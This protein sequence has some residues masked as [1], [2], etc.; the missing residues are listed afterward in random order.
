MSKQKEFLEKVNSK[1]DV[2]VFTLKEKEEE[3]FE[4]VLELGWVEVDDK[5]G[6]IELTDLGEKTLGLGKSETQKSGGISVY[7]GRYNKEKEVKKKKEAKEALE[8]INKSSPNG[9]SS[10]HSQVAEVASLCFAFGENSDSIKESIELFETVTN[11][12]LLSRKLS[13]QE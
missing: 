8:L 12:S 2:P 5:R 11:L 6:V 9:R 7:P 1:D 10:A 3:I 13:E 4:E